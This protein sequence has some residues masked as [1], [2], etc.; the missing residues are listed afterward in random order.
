MK[1]YLGH[2][3][4]NTTNRFYS[5]VDKARLNKTKNV[6]DEML[7]SSKMENRLDAAWTLEPEKTGKKRNKKRRR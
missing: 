1:F 3:N 5:I 4:L 7:K 2:S 6:M